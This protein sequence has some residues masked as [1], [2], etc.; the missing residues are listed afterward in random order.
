MSLSREAARLR[1]MFKRA[2]ESID[3]DKVKYLISEMGRRGYS[4]ATIKD[5]CYI[6][7]A[8]GLFQR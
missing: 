1:M 7:A 8:E 2:P 4:P 3:I 6:A 5:A